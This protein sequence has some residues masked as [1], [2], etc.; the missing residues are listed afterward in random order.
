MVVVVEEVGVQVEGVDR[1]ELG[2]VDQ[3]DPHR[4][5]ALDLDRPL[6]VGMGDRV[7]GVELVLLVEIGVEAVH[8]HHEL[9]PAR[10]LGRAEQAAARRLGVLRVPLR[11]RVDDE[12][13][14]EALVDVP[15]QR[16][17]VAVVE[18]AAE[19]LGR[20]TRRRTP[21]RAAISPAPG[22]PS[23]RAEWMPWKC[24][25]VRHVA[26]VEEADAQPVALGRAQGR[27][28]HAAIVGPGRKEHAGRD[29]DLL[30]DR[31]DLELAQPPA[32]GQGRHD[33]GVPVAED[34]MGIE[35]VTGVIDLADGGHPMVLRV[36][37]AKI[38]LRRRQG[39]AA[40]RPW[41]LRGQAARAEAE[42]AGAAREPDAEQGPPIESAPQPRLHRPSHPFPPS[43]S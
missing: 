27:T 33:A 8:H 23:M 20:R 28:G 35:A 10:V 22:T 19:G 38:V 3:I 15:L 34:G 1:V 37:Q 5:R 18:M 2:D 9:L 42:R 26:G 6:G 11:I 4:A 30:I 41:Q 36:R 40:A 16:Q 24:M 39:S 7:D 13:A 31:G 17:R 25:R 14:V 29:L 32:V 12:G 21:R 43:D